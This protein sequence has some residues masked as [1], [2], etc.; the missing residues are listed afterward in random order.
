MNILWNRVGHS[1]QC[2]DS[3]L[4]GVCKPQFQS[5]CRDFSQ[6]LVV[7]STGE[8]YNLGKIMERHLH[9]AGVHWSAQECT[10]CT[11]SPT[12]LFVKLESWNLVWMLEF[13][14]HKLSYKPYFEKTDVQWCTMVHRSAQGAHKVHIFLTFLSVKLESWNLVWMLEFEF[15][16]LSYKPYFEKNR[17]AGVHSGAQDAQSAHFP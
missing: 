14:F 12:F 5:L 3:L 2:L 6:N 1:A 17:C 10:K 13:E 9:R 16:Q 8:W 11:F 7:S 4:G 15:H